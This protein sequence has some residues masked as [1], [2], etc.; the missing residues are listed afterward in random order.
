M[1]NRILIS[2][3][4]SFIALAF[5]SCSRCSSSKYKYDDAYWKSVNREKALKDAGYDRAAKEERK[6]RQ[7]E[8]QRPS[9]SSSSK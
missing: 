9:S 6:N 8:M 1:K 3:A 2:L 4:M 5:T 7:K